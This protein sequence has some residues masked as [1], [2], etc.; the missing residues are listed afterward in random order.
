MA[1]AVTA[2]DVRATRRVHHATAVITLRY[3]I[4]FRF[5]RTSELT[6]VV[7]CLVELSLPY[8][9]P[10]RARP[11]FR[12]RGLKSE[13][14]GS[15]SADPEGGEQLLHNRYV[16]VGV[17]GSGSVPFSGFHVPVLGPKKIRAL[18][19]HPLFTLFPR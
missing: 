16:T 18:R 2:A 6:S 13:V 7:T 8:A 15:G 10:P 3:R 5:A 11:R 14:P 12:F 4:L 17:P 19:A 9:Y 1:D